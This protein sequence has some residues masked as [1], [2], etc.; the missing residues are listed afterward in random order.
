MN[1]PVR[2]LIVLLV[3]GLLLAACGVPATTTPPTLPPSERAEAAPT[4]LPTAVPATTAPTDKAVAAPAL[5]RIGAKCG[6]SPHAM[7]LFIALAQHNGGQFA[8]G[9]VEFVPVT[10]PAQM[11][12]LLSNAQV[13]AMVGFIVETANIFQKGEVSDLR[14]LSVPLWRAFSIVGTEGLTSWAD[15][16]GQTILMSD[17]QGGPSQLA[18][19]SMQQ[20]GFNPETDFTIQYVPEAQVLQLMLAGEASAAAVSEPFS[21]I[22]INRSR[23]QGKMPLSIAPISLSAVYQAESAW[24][25]DTL[26]MVGLLARQPVLDDPASL[27]LLHEFEAAYYEAMAF[28][29]ANPAEAS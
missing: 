25:G 20:A 2:L 12:A 19:A 15:L 10:E 8:H 7:P 11:T 16:K 18:R 6:P 9:Q 1:S 14:L 24:P 26:P 22:L 29:E 4:A 21:T 3:M 27:A 13:D 23:T 17:P 28:M 5:L